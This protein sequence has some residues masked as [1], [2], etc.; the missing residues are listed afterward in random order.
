MNKSMIDNAYDI[1]TATGHELTFQDLVK[2]VADKDGIADVTTL[3]PKL[4][5]FYTD[6]SLDGRFVIL[7]NNTWDLRDRHTSDQVRIDMNEVYSSD[8][9]DD[10][11]S[12]LGQ[13]DEGEIPDSHDDDSDDDD[14]GNDTKPVNASDLENS[15]N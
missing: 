1:L 14:N 2:A 5:S 8:E 9:S 12:E 3:T 10:K 11:V 4:G 13:E 15:D 7:P 6:L